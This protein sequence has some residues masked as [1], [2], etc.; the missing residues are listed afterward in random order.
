M[1]PI[2]TNNNSTSNADTPPVRID[3]PSNKIPL[4]LVIVDEGN[5]SFPTF[6]GKERGIPPLI[7]D[8]KPALRFI[9]IIYVRLLTQYVN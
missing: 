6:P 4:L 3:T 2:M 8:W 7:N 1:W 9:W 5:V